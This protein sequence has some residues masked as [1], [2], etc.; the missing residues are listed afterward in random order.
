[1]DQKR[2]SNHQKNNHSNSTENKKNNSFRRKCLRHRKM[3]EMMRKLSLPGF[4]NE[5]IEE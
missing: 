3:I 5:T 4:W 1:M 2:H